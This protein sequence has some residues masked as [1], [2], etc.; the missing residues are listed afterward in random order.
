MAQLPQASTPDPTGLEPASEPFGCEPE[1]VGAALMI[2]VRRAPRFQE[3]TDMLPGAIWHDPQEVELW[4]S[5]Y[6]SGQEIVVYCVHGHEVSRGTVMALKARG[7]NA[8]FLRGGIEAWRAL[9][10]PLSLKR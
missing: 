4:A 5:R 9:G 10:L 7:L 6:T 3:A 2:D 8:R 1:D